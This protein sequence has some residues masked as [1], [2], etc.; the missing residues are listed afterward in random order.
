MSNNEAAL[1]PPKLALLHGLLFG[2]GDVAIETL[3]AGMS[4]PEKYA[5]SNRTMGSWLGPYIT[6]LNRRIVKQKLRVVPGQRK[7][8]YALVVTR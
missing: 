4:G 5:E 8:T 3:F 2:R 7:R 1:L 6:R